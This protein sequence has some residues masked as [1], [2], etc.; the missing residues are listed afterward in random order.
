MN[1]G[2]DGY[3]AA[4][5]Q[6]AGDD[7]RPLAADLGAIERLVESNPTLRSALTDTAVSA[8]ARR[9]VVNE[10]LQG[11]VRPAACR[12]AAFAAGAVSAPEVPVALAWVAQRAH[13]A[14]ERQPE[15]DVPLGFTAS[16]ARVGGFAA[17]LYEDVA[18]SEL[19]EVEDELF[20]FGRTVETTPALRVALS[21]RDLPVT[22]RQAVVDQLLEGKAHEATVRLADYVIE[23]GRPRDVVGTLFWLAEQTARARGWRVARVAAAGEIDPG[24][25]DELARSLSG[26]TGGPVE[27]QVVIDPSLLSGLRVRI[28]D[29]QVDATARGRLDRLREHLMPAGWEESGFASTRTGGAPE[30]AR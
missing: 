5:I 25:S 1:P 18:T 20:R 13:R 22:V 17:A 4:V 29:L 9:A 28:G 2:L 10:L 8:V 23:G 3:V 27:L 11:K 19:E 6:D 24:Q 15:I 30:G 26:L 14:A 21:N 7:L 12:V 16:R